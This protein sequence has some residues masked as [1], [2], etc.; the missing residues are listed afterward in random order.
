[1]GEKDQKP[2][3]DSV[4]SVRIFTLGRFGIEVNG[5]QIDLPVR[6]RNRQLD[7]LKLLVS[8]N[9]NTAS[10]SHLSEALWPD[11]DG[12]QAHGS[13]SVTLNRLRKLIGQETLNLR[14]ARLSLNDDI[15]WID[16]T[17][18]H[19]HIE[20]TDIALE[21]SDSQTAL[22]EFDKALTLYRG[23]F[24]EGEFDF[25]DF[26][27]ARDRLHRMLLQTLEK[28]GKWLQDHEDFEK[29]LSMYQ[30]VLE[31]D[32]LNEEIYYNL[33]VCHQKR[34]RPAEAIGAYHQ[35]HRM[36]QTGLGIKPSENLE[37]LYTALLQEQQSRN[38]VE[39]ANA[40]N[41][42]SAEAP[43][44]NNGAAAGSPP[45]GQNHI[46]AAE[47]EGLG[48]AGERRRATVVCSL[49]SGFQ[50]LFSQIDPEL[51]SEIMV[52]IREEATLAVEQYGGVVN[53]FVR[54]EV[55]SFFGVPVTHEDDPSNA[56]MA[57]MLLHSSVRSVGSEYEKKL[58]RPLVMKTGIASGLMVLHQGD[59]RGGQFSITGDAVN[60]A[61]QLAEQ[62][63]ADDLLVSRETHDIVR[64]F[65]VSEPNPAPTEPD[66]TGPV[67]FRVLSVS[68]TRTRFEA[69]ERKGL[70][71]YIGRTAELDF[72]KSCTER[73]L[74]GKG[75]FVTIEGE[76]GLGKSRLIHEFQKIIS[77]E[78]ITVLHA[79][80]QPF[81]ITTPYLPFLQALRQGLRLRDSDSAQRMKE[82]VIR[83]TIKIS[84]QLK[85]YLPIYLHMLSLKSDNHP[86]PL[87]LQGEELRGALEEALAAIISIS[88]AMRP[89]IVLMEDWHWSDPG[90]DSVVH[91]LCEGISEYPLLV[92]MAYRPE[93]DARWGRM[94][95]HRHIALKP[96]DA[97]QTGAMITPLFGDAVP[98]EELITSIHHRTEGNPFFI[99]EM[100]R[101]LQEQG[102]V[103]IDM[104]VAVMA[105]SKK[106]II[107]P[108]TVQALVRSRVDRLP[109]EDLDVL[110]LASVIGEE[111]PRK[112]LE[113]V[114][115]DPQRLSRNLSEL[116]RMEM[117]QQMRVFPEVVFRFNHI[118]TQ[119]VVYDNLL[120]QQR[121]DLHERV[122]LAIEGIY[123][124]RLEEHLE[125]LAHHFSRTGNIRKAIAYLSKAGDKASRMF[126]FN[127]AR[128]HYLGA[129]DLIAG[130]ELTP[131]IQRERMDITLKWAQVSFY[132]PSRHLLVSLETALEDARQLKDR[133]R[134]IRATIWIGMINYA[135]GN[136]ARAKEQ[137][138]QCREVIGGSD[139]DALALINN[140]LG[141]V[142]FYLSNFE[143]G[144]ELLTRGIPQL[145]TQGKSAEAAN[146]MA[147]LGLIKG[148]QG[149]FAGSRKL[150]DQALAFAA[151]GKNPGIE[152]ISHVC[153]GIT[154]GLRGAWP[155]AIGHMGRAREISNQV[156]NLV[157][158]GIGCWGEG[159][160]DVHQDKIEQGLS[161]M[162]EGI[163][164]IEATGSKLCLSA[165]YGVLAE[166]YA[167]LK[168]YR[169]AT[170]FAQRSLDLTREGGDSLG[171]YNAY[172]ALA[173]VCFGSPEKRDE[174]DRN[175][176]SSLALAEEKKARPDLT[177]F[178]LQLA[179]MYLEQGDRKKAR[180]YF[181]RARELLDKLDMPWWNSK[182]EKLAEILEKPG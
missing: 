81:G 93:Y 30:Q 103:E 16:S 177:R 104:G 65:F 114:C 152:A 131:E 10:I 147:I 74:S 23:P 48:L 98:S 101:A 1:M 90:S 119:M 160:A 106:P 102:A 15:A 170:L 145:D 108:D 78:D 39:H 5:S 4:S 175:I 174:L 57:A 137:L 167:A 54:G 29:A 182:A 89:M 161:R 156:G 165:F 53:Q 176:Q 14:N 142:H 68:D 158:E 21:G 42:A 26:L 18:F 181:S 126:S 140:Y 116:R 25:S 51:A 155:Q 138:E 129:L 69:A 31:V 33:M 67:A 115:P 157:M 38:G 12:D 70:T 37:N 112:V 159:Y 34:G 36:L 96:L 179:A 122:G 164:L 45:P 168:N 50:S 43:P 28:L 82:K 32:E 27:S 136:H 17:S 180:E 83:N 173:L 113:R 13:F 150:T 3:P 105:S 6:G 141:R 86:F 49:I 146:S 111:F 151:R 166:S 55:L 178:C 163:S 117:I 100:C 144:T 121:R 130:E 11:A 169:K 94:D 19:S 87:Q 71:P 46:S 75:Q 85:Q 162:H 99:E 171:D 59:Q 125:S 62:A 132:L 60:T 128:R 40:R 64:P 97:D 92:I 148:Y 107:I 84:P 41:S 109:P 110:R 139:E 66:E 124:D 172:F 135:L 35:C 72:L 153:A 120:L 8:Q 154:E 2:T 149:D 79:R 80:C 9:G 24:L 127:E 143:Q 73:M 7:L 58:N 118:I 52:R 77:H 22:E 61:A 20:N 47:P 76:A 91:D 95:H 123:R 63:R 88:V 56:V 44:R 134:M 133:L